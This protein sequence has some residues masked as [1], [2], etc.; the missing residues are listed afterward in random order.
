MPATLTSTTEAALLRSILESPQDDTVRLAYADW[1]EEHG[2]EAR[3]KL[4]MAQIAQADFES[5]PCECTSCPVCFDMAADYE[6]NVVECRNC[7]GTGLSFM[8]HRCGK[9]DEAHHQTWGLLFEKCGEWFGDG[10]APYPESVQGGFRLNTVDVQYNLSRGFVSSISLLAALFTQTVV[11]PIFER[12]PVVE[13]KL[14]DIELVDFIC[15]NGNPP[16]VFVEL[17]EPPQTPRLNELPRDVFEELWLLSPKYRHA[18][19]PPLPTR[20]PSLPTRWL[21]Y[22]T[23]YEACKALSTALVRL[24]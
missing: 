24:G 21:E 19:R 18:N 5:Q 6:T 10:M 4:V 12:P 16:W 15:R 20:W 14:M 9:I 23:K 7:D 13:V 1:C 22:P 8:C 17:G 3:G 2:Q 11:G